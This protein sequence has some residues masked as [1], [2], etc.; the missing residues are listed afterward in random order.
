[1]NLK[2]WKR[3]TAA[4]GISLTLL[5]A[6]LA[7]AP[8]PTP[9]R[10]LLN[11]QELFTDTPAIL[12]EGTTY[13][14][15]RAFAETFS[16]AEVTWDGRTGTAAVHAPGL[17]LTVQDGKKYM[18]ANGRC[19][20]MAQSI[21]KQDGRV[22]VPVRALSAAYGVDVVW[23]AAS[24]TVCLTGESRPAQSGEQFYDAD[25]LLWLA[26]IIH[27]ESQGEPLDGKIAVGNVVLNRVRSAD[28][29]N[30]IYGVIFDQA[31]GV[32]FTPVANGTVYNTPNEESVAAAKLCLE[33]AST[34]P[35]NCLY[36]IN[37][38]IASSLWVP[39]NRPYIKDIGNHQFY[40]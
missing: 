20:Y 6:P 39:Q 12:R 31:N 11:G 19:F 36:F 25:E 16:Q 17:E 8:G 22:L 35:P 23:D 2:K 24:R 26:R 40:A 37:A 30:T 21:V 13:V 1:M 33:G 27:A 5:A 14:P 32:Q 29:P 15:L 28:F 34:V 7:A 9:V 3:A 10:V 18:T 4:F 38:S